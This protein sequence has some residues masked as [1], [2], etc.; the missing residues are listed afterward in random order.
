MFRILAIEDERKGSFGVSMNHSLSSIELLSNRPVVVFGE[1][2]KPEDLSFSLTVNLE[3]DR[4]DIFTFD[5]GIILKNKFSHVEFSCHD[6]KDIKLSLNIALIMPP[7]CTFQPIKEFYDPK[8]YIIG[9]RGSGNNLITQE[10][11]ENSLEGF[12]L[13]QSRGAQYVEC[14]IQMAKDGTPVITHPF[15]HTS[16]TKIPD[17]D[18]YIEKDGKFLYTW[19]QLSVEQHHNSTLESQWK[20]PRCTLEDMLDNLKQLKGIFAEVKYPFGKGFNVQPYFERNY[21]VDQ[22]LDLFSKKAQHLDLLLGSFDPFVTAM[23]AL[24]QNRFKVFV[25]VGENIVDMEALRPL[26]RRLGIFGY[27]TDPSRLTTHPHFFKSVLSEGAK[28]VG[29]NTEKSNTKEGILEMKELGFSGVISDNVPVLVE[30]AR[31][32]TCDE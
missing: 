2:P 20:L 27:S 21:F 1:S 7:K 23:L 32:I 19:A 12:T 3:N 25:L 17:I 10:I 5:A 22:I 8:F 6:A 24:K 18:E 30:T 9:H 15:Y 16:D 31:E 28:L 4:M 14:D 11:M 29:Y 26:H 13:A